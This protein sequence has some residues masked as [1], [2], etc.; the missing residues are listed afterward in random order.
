MSPGLTVLEQDS[1]PGNRSSCPGWRTWMWVWPAHMFS[2]SELDHWWTFTIEGQQFS[3][4]WHNF[5]GKQHAH[6]HTRMQ[7]AYAVHR[8]SLE[9]IM[10]PAGYSTS[11]RNL[12][13]NWPGTFYSAGV[14]K[15]WTGHHGV[16]HQT[17]VQTHADD[18]SCNLHVCTDHTCKTNSYNSET[19]IVISF[20]ISDGI[21]LISPATGVQSS[22][23]VLVLHICANV[24][25]STT[26]KH[27]YTTLYICKD[28]DRYVPNSNIK[29]N[30]RL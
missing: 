23:M 20:L 19:W 3:N 6:T 13:W 16:L 28:F 1:E 8:C 15:P 2:K 24:V 9:N 17:Q 4:I 22:Q 27:T 30:T 18:S 21:K 29:T 10:C 26:H 5:L 25:Q 7:H 14:R 12:E 11:P